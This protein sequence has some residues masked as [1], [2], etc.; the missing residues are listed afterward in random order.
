HFIS[1]VNR[2]EY[3]VAEGENKHH[4][5]EMM[6]NKY[7]KDLLKKGTFIVQKYIETRTIDGQPFDI[8]VHMMKDGNGEWSFVNNYPELVSIMHLYP[9]P[10][11]RDILEKYMAF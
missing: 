6:L 10:E 2:N 3:F 9:L 5:D 4:Y 7:L 11:K 8:R 1:K